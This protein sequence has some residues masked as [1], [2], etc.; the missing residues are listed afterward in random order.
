VLARNSLVRAKAKAIIDWRLPVDFTDGN[1]SLNVVFKCLDELHA[2]RD[3][4][5]AD[6]EV[7]TLPNATGLPDLLGS[8]LGFIVELPDGNYFRGFL[9]LVMRKTGGN[10]VILLELKTSINPQEHSYRYSMQGTLYQLFLM[11][12]C[13]KYGIANENVAVNYQVFNV[14]QLEWLPLM[15]VKTKNDFKSGLQWLL[16]SSKLNQMYLDSGTWPSSGGYGVCN[17][18]GRIC[19]FYG[20]CQNDFDKLLPMALIPDDYTYVDTRRA[21]IANTVVLSYAE[22]EEV[23][24]EY[25]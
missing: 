2:I 15:F 5:F 13:R 7:M 22:L 17:S 1:R 19:Q 21:A 12:L 8:E 23:A 3:T 4:V 20:S 11:A 24:N 10:E 18:F 9:D 16:A 6:W 25:A 14:K